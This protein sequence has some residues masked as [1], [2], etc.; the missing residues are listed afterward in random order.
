MKSEVLVCEVTEGRGKRPTDSKKLSVGPFTHQTRAA[1]GL[2]WTCECQKGIFP[3][4]AYI[5]SHVVGLLLVFALPF[6]PLP[7]P[8]ITK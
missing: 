6:F 7:Q 2:L 5:V 1:Q 8:I 4:L 3:T